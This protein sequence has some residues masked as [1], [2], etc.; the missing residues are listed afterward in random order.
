MKGHRGKS[1]L[2]QSRRHAFRLR[3]AA[4]IDDAALVLV[5]RQEIQQL[6]G[7]ADL[8]F[9]GKVQ[10][11]AVEAGNEDLGLFHAQGREDVAAGAGIGRGGQ[12]D[13]RHAG[14]QVRQTGQFAEFGPELVAP[15]RHAMRFVDRDQRN[16]Q[17]RQPVERAVAQQSFGR[18]IEQVQLLLQQVPRDGSRFR[19]VQFRVQG[20]G[21]DPDLAQ[22]GNLIV[23][24]SDQGGHDHRHARPTERGHLVA[25]AL[26]AAGGHQHQGVAARDHVAHRGF[27]LPAKPGKAEDAMQHTRGINRGGR[28]HER[29]I[30]AC[31]N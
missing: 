14:E 15:L 11:G 10:V 4:A 7:F 30:S 23:H 2:P 28:R 29:G 25:D 5:A 9:G 22:R 6:G 19:R 16:V 8:G 17:P 31:G 24:Q 1:L 3:S 20:A 26:A 13:P 21:V 12:R 18:D 27:L